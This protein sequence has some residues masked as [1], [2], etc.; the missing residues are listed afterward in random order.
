MNLLQIDEEGVN[1]VIKIYKLDK[2]DKFGN[3]FCS[4]VQPAIP[5]KDP[6]NVSRFLR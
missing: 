4:R 2:K 6:T 5:D 3:P 1:P